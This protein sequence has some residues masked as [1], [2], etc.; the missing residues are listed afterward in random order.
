MGQ[1]DNNHPVDDTLD[2][3][4]FMTNQTCLAALDKT[5]TTIRRIK[6]KNDLAISAAR[7]GSI[8]YRI[9]R[10]VAEVGLTLPRKLPLDTWDMFNGR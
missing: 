9:Q 1:E 7:C 6:D 2:R 10:C 3:L 5:L 4:V 8:A